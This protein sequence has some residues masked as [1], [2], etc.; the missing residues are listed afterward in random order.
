[1]L[2]SQDTR[3][4]GAKE[5]HKEPQVLT[6]SDEAS[7]E[8][9]LTWKQQLVL[10]RIQSTHEWKIRGYIPKAKEAVFQSPSGTLGI[11]RGELGGKG[12]VWSWKTNSWEGK[13]T[14]PLKWAEL[15]P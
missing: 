1:M 15:C 2:T 9:S 12:D 6:L 8:G 10:W 5:H 11:S 7:L 14:N 13:S 4:L 3:H